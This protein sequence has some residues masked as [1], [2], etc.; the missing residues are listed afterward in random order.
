MTGFLRGPN[1]VAKVPKTKWS[2]TW[3]KAPGLIIC[4]PPG[5]CCCLTNWHQIIEIYSR[6]P[7]SDPIFS[8][9]VFIFGPGRRLHQHMISLA[10]CHKMLHLYQYYINTSIGEF[11]AKS[12]WKFSTLSKMLFLS[13]IIII[14]SPVM[15]F[16][17][18]WPPSPILEAI[19]GSGYV[20]G[21]FWFQLNFSNFFWRFCIEEVK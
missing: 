9:K 21:H 18:I 13:L 10:Y 7:W 15:H 8:S 16:S 3:A 5:R 2:K 20:F 19:F 11:H 17:Q 6:R 1:F 4:A 12:A 14:R